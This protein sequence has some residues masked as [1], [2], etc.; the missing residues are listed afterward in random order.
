MQMKYDDVTIRTAFGEAALEYAKEDA[1]TYFIC[2]DTVKSMGL[3]ELEKAFPERCFNVGICEQNAAL[4]AAGIASCGG[5]VFVG[6]F[7][8]FASMRMLEQVRTFVAYPN[9]DVKIVSC[10][11]GLSGGN[12]G[13]THQGIEDISIMRG[14]ANMVIAV[15]GDAASARA[16]TKKVAAHK[17][18]AYLRLGKVA[19]PKVYDESYQ[20]EIGKANIIKDD[21]KDAA[22]I[23]IGVTAS[24]V[25]AAAELLEQKGIKVS[26]IEMPSIKPIDKEAIIN[27]AKNTGAVIT[28]EDNNIIGG[29]GSAVAEV[30]SENYPVYMKRI[31]I[32]DCFTESGD[33]GALLDKYGL[34]AEAIVEKVETLV[35]LK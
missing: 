28:V 29:L 6:S 10:M 32:E 3:D 18:P 14:I 11:A 35:K 30:L 19:N 21:G 13:V 24:R 31:G 5:T 34:S 9:L 7:A 27:A 33:E 17:G 26:L 20:F 1:N 16:I 15:A 23:F 25:L 4:M 8:P 12:E 22:I 2:P